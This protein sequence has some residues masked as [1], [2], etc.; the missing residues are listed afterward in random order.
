[1]S[2]FP[3]LSDRWSDRHRCVLDR[4]RSAMILALRVAEQDLVGSAGLH[5]RQAVDKILEKE[6][7]PEVFGQMIKLVD[8]VLPITDMHTTLRR[9]CQLGGQAQMIESAHAFFL[10][11]RYPNRIDLALECGGPL[12]LCVRP[13]FAATRQT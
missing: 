3:L 13:N 10:A 4:Q 9:A 5:L 8:V 2:V 1:M 12:E 7:R 11:D 6:I